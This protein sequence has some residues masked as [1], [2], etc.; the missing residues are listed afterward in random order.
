MT[1][2]EK[3][4]QD[5]ESSMYQH[6]DSVKADDISH[7]VHHHCDELDEK[8]TQFQHPVPE[9][10][11]VLR[12]FDTNNYY[13]CKC[14]NCGWEDSSEYAAGGHSIGDTGDYSDAVCPIC[15]SDKIEGETDT[16]L[17]NEYDGIHFIKIPLN[18]F[19]APYQKAAKRAFQLEDEKYWN[20]VMMN[21]KSLHPVPDEAGIKEKIKEYLFNTAVHGVNIDAD[22]LKQTISFLE[23]LPT[24]VPDDA[25]E[26]VNI[27]EIMSAL[28]D[29]YSDGGT[30]T[31]GWFDRIIDDFIKTTK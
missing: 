20:N 26:V 6:Q 25:G 22:Y 29:K 27:E 11:Y 1:T 19:L 4:M 31:K 23:S 28:W 2:G 3:I 21:E 16:P 9:T 10:E 18:T 17:P 12:K 8:L 13:W 24:S 7:I 15:C 5:I 30:I 14:E